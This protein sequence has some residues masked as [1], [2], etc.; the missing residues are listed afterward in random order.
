MCI[1]ERNRLLSLR[2]MPAEFHR[3]TGLRRKE[4]RF[5]SGK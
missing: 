3:R 5:Q 4:L 2:Y 1:C